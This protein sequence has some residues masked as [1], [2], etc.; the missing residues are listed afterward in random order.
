MESVHPFQPFL[1]DEVTGKTIAIIGTGRIG[2]AMIKKC[3]GFD[4][5]IFVLHASHPN[6]A[7]VQAIQEIRIC[8][9]RAASL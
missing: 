4:M 3:V 7:F 9:L 2:C 8:S 6:H 1:G 5:N